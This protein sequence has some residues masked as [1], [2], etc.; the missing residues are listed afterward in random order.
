MVLVTWAR[1]FKQP[2]AVVVRGE[3]TDGREA[4]RATSAEATA[5][6]SLGGAVDPDA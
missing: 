5:H 3:P 6:A 2:L 1:V 4:K